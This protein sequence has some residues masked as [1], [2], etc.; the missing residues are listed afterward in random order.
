[1]AYVVLEGVAAFTVGGTTVEACSG[2]LVAC[3]RN[4]PHGFVLRTPTARLLVLVTP[5]G[6]EAFVAAAARIDPGDT[7]LL[8]SLAAEHRCDVLAPPLP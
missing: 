7:Q 5:A 3:P 2:T 8:L 1:V 4:V 6:L